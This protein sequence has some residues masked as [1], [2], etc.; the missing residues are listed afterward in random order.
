V[1]PTF[2][3]VNQKG[4]VGKTTTAVNLGAC[5]AAQGRRVLLVDVDPQGNAT[6]GLGVDKKS[7]S[8]SI[9]DCLTDGRPV[10]EV[11]V[12]TA[13]ENL[14]VVPATVDL[15]GAE[16]ELVSELA[17]ESRLK[18]CLEPVVDRYDY[19]L[20]DS[21]PSLGL[22]TI[23]CLTAADSVII[24]I[25]CEYYALEGLSQLQNTLDLVSRALNPG[26]D[27]FGV[28]LTMFDSRTRLSTEVADEVRRHFPGRVFRSVIPRTVR[29]SEAPIYGQPIIRYAPENRAA[30]AYTDLAREVIEI[31]EAQ[32]AAVADTSG[33]AVGAG[34]DDPGG[35]GGAAVQEPVPAAPAGGGGG[36]GG[37]G[38]VGDDPWDPAAAGGTEAGERAG[39]DRWG[40]EAGGGALELVEADDGHGVHHDEEGHEEGDHVG[41]GEEPAHHARA[42]AAGLAAF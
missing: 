7:L 40:A 2:A 5:L 27:I 26:L 32:G 10:A 19:V 24:P 30:E 17:R 39:A 11:T 33:D 37:S 22:L 31:A 14:S 25:Q 8:A 13:V 41:V 42:F 35:P 12:E 29:L 4:G 28:V 20:L 3:I 15:A 9:Y 18:A 23:N 16:V 6:S 38:D 1:R 34:G 36:S 21:P